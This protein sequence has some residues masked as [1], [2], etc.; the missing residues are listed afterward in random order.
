[1][2]NILIWGAVII[3]LGAGIAVKFYSEESQ[4]KVKR[5]FSNAT[6]Y[7]HGQV[8]VYTNPPQRFLQVEKL[9]SAEATDGDSSRSYRYGWGYFD[10]NLNGVVDKNEKE[11]GKNYFDINNFSP[12]SYRDMGST[13]F[14]E[15]IK[16]TKIN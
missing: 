9:S 14:E 8:D 6:G 11:I 7:K 12:I 13:Q 15:S 2:K 4:N 3:A 1:M 10:L 16:S 5:Y